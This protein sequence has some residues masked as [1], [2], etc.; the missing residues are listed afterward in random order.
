[1]VQMPHTSAG[2]LDLEAASEAKGSCAVYV[3]QPNAFGIIDEGLMR[4][5]SIIGDSTSLIVGVDAV[6]LGVLEAPG[7]WGA[8]IVV[9]EG[10]PFGIGPT[11]GGP[12]YGIFACTKDYLRLMPGRIVGQS[13][14]SDGRIAYTLTLSTREQHIRLSL[15]HI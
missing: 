4:L 13:K 2:L 1:M 9:G 8:D 3:E 6:S 5:R 14:D 15:I 7:N 10:Q 11:G 12:I